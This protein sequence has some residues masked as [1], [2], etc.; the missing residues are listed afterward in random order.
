M[1][2]HV[3][4]TSDWTLE[5]SPIDDSAG[6]CDSVYYCAFSRN[7]EFLLTA[8]VMLR[9]WRVTFD[10]DGVITCG[11][12]QHLQ[13]LVASEGF[14]AATFCGQY[15]TIV[16]SSRDGCLGLWNK[17]SGL[18]VEVSLMRRTS[19]PGRKVVKDEESDGKVHYSICLDLPKPM[20][21]VSE[22]IGT[23]L[24]GINPPSKWTHT[25][26]F[27]PR[28]SGGRTP[29]CLFPAATLAKAGD[30][31][32]TPRPSTS[33]GYEMPSSQGQSLLKSSST[34]ELRRMATIESSSPKRWTSK[35]LDFDAIFAN[36]L[37][38]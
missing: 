5:N 10:R 3:W 20:R 24:Q 35:S 17:R 38:P 14:R 18:P 25:T 12:H 28:T 32:S 6:S 2:L 36:S 31:A 13:A 21:K 34:P 22:P 16:G 33:Q 37:R 19:P 1:G 15:D 23:G 4:R 11:I 27:R 29:M 9:I 26:S 8:G 7:C 30:L